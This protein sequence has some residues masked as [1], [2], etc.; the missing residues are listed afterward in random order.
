MSNQKEI[1]IKEI[2]PD[3]LKKEEFKVSHFRFLLP[4]VLEKG[5]MYKRSELIRKLVSAHENIT[6]LKVTKTIENLGHALKK[7][8][9]RNDNLKQ[10]EHSNGGWIYIGESNSGKFNVID[11]QSINEELSPIKKQPHSKY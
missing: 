11:E 10:A 7:E 5:E 2:Y 4:Y 1:D 6:G 9:R 3:Y 8:F